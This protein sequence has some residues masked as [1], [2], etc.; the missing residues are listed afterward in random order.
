[1][2]ELLSKSFSNLKVVHSPFCWLIS[3]DILE[4]VTPPPKIEI[5]LPNLATDSRVCFFGYDYESYL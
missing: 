2:S 1:M 4:N 3:A 5:A